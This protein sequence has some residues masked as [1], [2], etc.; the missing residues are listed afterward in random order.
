MEG[1]RERTDALGEVGVCGTLLLPGNVDGTDGRS[2]NAEDVRSS[3]SSMEG[4]FEVNSD[5]EGKCVDRGEGLGCEVDCE[6]VDTN[7]DGGADMAG[8]DE[9]DGV[10][11]DAGVI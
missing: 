4:K 2:G 5:I 1:N 7:G 3:S 8:D 11:N 9:E 6:S 10:P